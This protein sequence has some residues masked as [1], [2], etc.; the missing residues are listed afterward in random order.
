MFNCWWTSKELSIQQNQKEESEWKRT[1]ENS[2]WGTSF[3][4]ATL[5]TSC[6]NDISNISS[7]PPC[8]RP[9]SPTT[10]AGS[11]SDHKFAHANGV[12]CRMCIMNTLKFWKMS[13]SVSYLFLFFTFPIV[14]HGSYS[15]WNSG[16][17]VAFIR[18]STIHSELNSTCTNTNFPNWRLLSKVFIGLNLALLISFLD[19][20]SVST[21][22][23]DIA[24]D[25]KAGNRSVSL[26]FQT[27]FLTDATR[28][29]QYKLD[30]D[31]VSRC[32]HR[33][34]DHYSAFKRYIWKETCLDRRCMFLKFLKQQLKFIPS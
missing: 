4:K 22:L 32:K 23:P 18:L 27:I 10:K 12:H 24:A 15:S 16:S 25:L 2:G 6:H 30:R 31:I 26:V 3:T 5:W 7:F 20:T 34:P 13:W 28:L 29:P 19:A 8:N 14:D 21:A 9:S 33:F 17:N 1:L 11:V